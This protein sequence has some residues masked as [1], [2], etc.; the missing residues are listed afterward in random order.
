MKFVTLIS[1]VNHIEIVH[2]IQTVEKK[3]SIKLSRV[4]FLTGQR[5][6]KTTFNAK[7]KENSSVENDS[8]LENLFALNEN[9]I[10]Q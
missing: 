6:I 8:K 4:L 10:K 5:S 2:G 1:L 7:Y 9:K 3:D